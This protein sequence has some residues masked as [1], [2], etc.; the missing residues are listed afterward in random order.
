MEKQIFLTKSAEETQKV[1][2][3]I[4][5]D[6]LSVKNRK[7]AAVLALEGELGAGKTT[8]VQGLAKAMGI[9]EKITTPTFLILKRFTIYDLRF[10]SEFENIFHID[11]YRLDKPDE[12]AELGFEEVLKDQKNLIVIEWA[13]KVKSIIPKDAVWVKF[14]WVDENKRKIQIFNE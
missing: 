11:C 7:N 9:K 10:K 13:D 1:A 8:F 5:K 2:G 3:Q 4:L 12:L 6:V 14:E